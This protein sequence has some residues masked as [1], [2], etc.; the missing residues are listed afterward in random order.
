MV[1]QAVHIYKLKGCMCDG[2]LIILPWPEK[3]T[4]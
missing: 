4:N 3:K 2:N 1:P